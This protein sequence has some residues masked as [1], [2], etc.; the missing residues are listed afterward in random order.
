MHVTSMSNP[1]DLVAFLEQ[2]NVDEVACSALT[3][4]RG[5]FRREVSHELYELVHALIDGDDA[6]QLSDLQFWLR[7]ERA[8][9]AFKW[10]TDL[11]EAIRVELDV[12]MAP[13]VYECLLAEIEKSEFDPHDEP[14][15]FLRPRP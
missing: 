1:A 6:S 11:V 10:Q 8:R 14:P 9:R 2:N 3:R 4:L 15:L 7:T 13:H 12:P 5:F